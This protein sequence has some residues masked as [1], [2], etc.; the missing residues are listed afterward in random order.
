MTRA[1]VSA[2]VDFEWSAVSA[3]KPC[4]IC[5]AESGCRVHADAGFAYCAQRP[6][7]WKLTNGAWLH[8][9]DDAPVYG[10][11]SDAVRDSE[12]LVI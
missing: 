3:A 11:A 4:P 2:A 7:D 6:S 1:A 12:A 9:L 10:V 8:R 5:G